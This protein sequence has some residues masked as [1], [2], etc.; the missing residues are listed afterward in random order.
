[1]VIALQCLLNQ[2][3]WH[4]SVV[5]EVQI[6][7]YYDK[8]IFSFFF[9][10][11]KLIIIF[12][13]EGWVGNGSVVPL[14]SVGLW[15]GSLHGLGNQGCLQMFRQMFNGTGSALSQSS[16]T[17]TAQLMGTEAQNPDCFQLEN[18]CWH[19]L[20]IK[21]L[22]C[23]LSRVDLYVCSKPSSFW[24]GWI[25]SV[26]SLYL[27]H[28]PNHCDTSWGNGLLAIPCITK[29]SGFPSG[30]CRQEMNELQITPHAGWI[31][32]WLPCGLISV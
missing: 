32:Q 28:S 16:C 29:V 8:K 24:P 1:M 31:K 14:S 19:V 25:Y 30:M 15:W 20:F 27:E 6:L 4:S 26:P 5:A 13:W 18:T 21:C 22:L 9:C 10:L 2:C 12:P 3:F 11:F 23:L 17:F 7:I